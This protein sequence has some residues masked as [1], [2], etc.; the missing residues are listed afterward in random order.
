MTGYTAVGC[1]QRLTASFRSLGSLFS[2]HKL[3]SQPSVATT[4]GSSGEW[5]FDVP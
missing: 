1:Y 4:E 2:K 5:A 3:F